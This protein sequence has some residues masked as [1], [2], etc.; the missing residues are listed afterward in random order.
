MKFLKTSRVRC[1]PAFYR[2]GILLNLNNLIGQLW[3]ECM[4]SML[5]LTQVDIHYSPWTVFGMV[6]I[7]VMSS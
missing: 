4:Q 5:L 6:L 3:K 1:R 2:R 7:F